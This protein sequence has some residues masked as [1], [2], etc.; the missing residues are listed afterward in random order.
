MAEAA[1]MTSRYMPEYRAE[2]LAGN[3]LCD[4]CRLLAA[5]GE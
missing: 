3:H 2:I 1:T 5:L 4:G